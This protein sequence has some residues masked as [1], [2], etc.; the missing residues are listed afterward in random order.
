MHCI[1]A[2]GFLP[3]ECCRCFMCG[4]SIVGS[5]TVNQPPP[6]PPPQSGLRCRGTKKA[7]ELRGGSITR[8]IPPPNDPPPPTPRRSF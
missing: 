6:P 5:T 8:T 1:V 7:R 2:G 4:T 3:H